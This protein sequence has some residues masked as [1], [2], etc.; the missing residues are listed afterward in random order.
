MNRDQKINVLLSRKE[1]DVR[2]LALDVIDAEARNTNTFGSKGHRTA[3]EKVEAQ[4]DDAR[5]ALESLTEPQLDAA[6]A[7]AQA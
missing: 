5:K 6:L 3:R 7:L 4:Y 1:E 2:R